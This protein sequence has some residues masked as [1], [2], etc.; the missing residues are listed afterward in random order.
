[1]QVLDLPHVLQIGRSRDARRSG[2]KTRPGPPFEVAGL[3]STLL[4][5]GAEYAAAVGAHILIAGHSAAAQSVTSQEV[6]QE[7]CVDPWAFRHAFAS[8]LEAVLPRVRSLKLDTPLMDLDPAQI[9]QLG[10]R[11]GVPFE[12]TWSC[13]QKTAPCGTCPGCTFRAGAFS[14]AGLPDPLTHAAAH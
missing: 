3:P 14:I 9:V 10:H 4:S 7:R 6:S 1:M 12:L 2:E 11:A 13:H 5:V 8:M